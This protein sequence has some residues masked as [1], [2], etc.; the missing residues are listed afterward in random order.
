MYTEAKKWK[1]AS[2]DELYPKRMASKQANI[3]RSTA[4]AS[5]NDVLALKA[6]LSI[7]WNKLRFLRRYYTG[8]T[9]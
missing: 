1:G 6:D 8:E 2:A 7:P 3:A 9:K 4:V 5:P